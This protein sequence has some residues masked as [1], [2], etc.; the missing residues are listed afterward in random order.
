VS[1][2]LDIGLFLRCEGRDHP[3]PATTLSRACLWERGGAG[4]E[5]RSV[6]KLGHDREVVGEAR[7]VGKPVRDPGFAAGLA[8]DAPP[9]DVSDQQPRNASQ[10]ASD[11]MNTVSES[12]RIMALIVIFIIVIVFW[13]VFHQN[14]STI[15]YFADDNTDWNVSGTISNSINA[16]W[17]LILTFPLVWF[18]GFLDRRGKEPSTPTKMAFGMTLTGLSF[19]VLGYGAYIGENSTRTSEQLATGEFRINERVAKNL[20]AQ[21]VPQATMDKLMA[22]KI[23]DGETTMVQECPPGKTCKPVINGVKFATSTNEATAVKTAGG[24]GLVAAMNKVEPG[25]GD[26]HRDKVLQASHLFRVSPFWLIFAYIIVTLGGLIPSPFGLS[27]GS[28]V[29]PNS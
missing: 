3:D 19:L 10:R 16:I 26:A 6:G 13:M 28:K 8:V 2:S 24:D 1:E 18:W 27:L 9:H 25:S 14:G 15:T 23:V 12:R 17:I 29:A 22:T 21:G 20:V 7:Q 5:A 4:R 11:L